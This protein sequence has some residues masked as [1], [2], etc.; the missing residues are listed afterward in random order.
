MYSVVMFSIENI[1]E[2][3]EEEMMELV[4]DEKERKEWIEMKLIEQGEKAQEML[5]IYKE[6]LSQE[7]YYRIIIQLVG[8]LKD[9]MFIELLE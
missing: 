7:V 1:N 4:I 8:E 6:W 5:V 3:I 9:S 2:F